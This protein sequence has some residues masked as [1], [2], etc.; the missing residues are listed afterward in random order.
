MNGDEKMNKKVSKELKNLAGRLNIDEKEMTTKYNEIATTNGIDLDEDRQQLICLTLTRNY[1]RGRINANKNTG[2][3][4]GFGNN[5]VG[6]FFAVEPARDVM[7]WKRRDVTNKYRSDSSQ[8]LTDEIVAEVSLVDGKYE[9][10]QVIK[11]EWNTKELPQLPSSA[12]EVGDDKWIVP[13]DPVK[14][15]ASGDV[16]KRYGKPLPAEEWR[17][18]AHFIGSKEGEDWQY[19]S[20]QLKGDAAN[21]FNTE[22]FRLVHLYGIFNDE[23]T[24]VYGIKNKTIASLTYNDLL[25]EEDERFYSNDVD[26][27][28]ML[29]SNMSEYV[30]DLME[31]ESYHE[32]ISTVQGLRLVVTDGIVSSMNLTV[33][34]K[35][36]NRVMWV[37]PVDA[38]Y[39]F[40]D[41]DIPE[42]TP[43]WVPSHINID[44]GVGS[45]VIIIGRTNQ[46]QR[47]DADGVPTGELNPVTINLYGVYARIATGA[48]AEDVVLDNDE[49]IEFW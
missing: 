42:S 47:K 43:V 9:K 39:G 22:T 6:F 23:R 13:I 46:T 8:A 16:N 37:E 15:W 48:V 34:E 38:N 26:M 4:S 7:E 30:S 5:A 17:L 29:G 3:N 49:D 18:R 20:V 40:E 14:S 11:G 45:D 32:Q 10:T 28:D 2:G 31:L 44:F 19:W 41:E 27:E 21:Q 24:A 1:V 12:I 33:N 36:G 35:T 25:D